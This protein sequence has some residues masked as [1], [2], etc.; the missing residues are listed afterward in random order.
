M[1]GR[2][3]DDYKRLTVVSTSACVTG[4]RAIL[5]TGSAQVHPVVFAHERSTS[6]TLH[7]WATQPR[8][9][10]GGSASKTSLIDPM[11]AS[12]RWSTRPSRKRRAPARSSG[13]TL[14]QA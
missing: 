6:A 2:V 11:H 9:V 7:A 3:F 14:S 10:N 8:G 12:P 13:Y 5:T 4:E 1:G